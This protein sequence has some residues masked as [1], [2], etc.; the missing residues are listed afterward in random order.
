METFANKKVNPE[1][2]HIHEVV[3]LFYAV[4]MPFGLPQLQKILQKNKMINRKSCI[5]TLI[6]CGSDDQKP[7]FVAR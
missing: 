2:K 3:V 1:K 7:V 5:S 6:T 4:G